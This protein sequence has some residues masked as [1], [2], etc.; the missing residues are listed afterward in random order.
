LLSVKRRS[1]VTPEEVGTVPCSDP[2]SYP[3]ISW[4]GR[5]SVANKWSRIC[6][7]FPVDGRDLKREKY[8]H[9]AP[10]RRREAK[11]SGNIEA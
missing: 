1:N 5:A 2:E 3:K 11:L 8:Y 4:K 7:L 10:S 6:F 9:V